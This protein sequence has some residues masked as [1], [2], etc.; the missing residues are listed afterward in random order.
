MALGVAESRL[1]KARLWFETL[2]FFSLLERAVPAVV[3]VVAET[4]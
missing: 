1:F 4:E 2:V 3:G